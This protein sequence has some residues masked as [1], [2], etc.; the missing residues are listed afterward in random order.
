[1]LP[2]SSSNVPPGTHGTYTSASLR[3]LLLQPGRDL[4]RKLDLISG[5]LSARR[6]VILPLD[7]RRAHDLVGGG[8]D[9]RDVG[10]TLVR[11]A[12]KHFEVDDVSRLVSLDVGDVVGELVA[13]AEPEVALAC[14]R[15][16]GVAAEEG[17]RVR[18]LVLLVEVD[19]GLSARGGRGGAGLP[20]DG[21]F[22]DDAVGRSQGDEGA[23]GGREEG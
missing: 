21:W 17:F 18:G 22:L 3:A 9:H 16:A 23:E 13:L 4:D 20:G 6:V 11:D 8:V 1:M 12:D 10:V 15:W 7:Q 5:G 2:P 14:V 19:E